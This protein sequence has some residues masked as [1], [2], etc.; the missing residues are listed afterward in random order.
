MEKEE[1][2]IDFGE[3]M[4]DLDGTTYTGIIKLYQNIE[5]FTKNKN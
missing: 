3:L 5:I 4:F 2:N 1:E